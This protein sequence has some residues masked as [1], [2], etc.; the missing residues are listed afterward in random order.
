VSFGDHWD[1]ALIGKNLTNRFVA[2]GVVDG[3]GTG[4]GTGTAAGIHADQIGLISLPRS[5]RLQFTW[6]Y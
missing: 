3:P 1:L 4:S 5:V 6:R 2:T